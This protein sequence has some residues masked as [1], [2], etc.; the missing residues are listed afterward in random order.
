MTTDSDGLR[1]ASGKEPQMEASKWLTV[2][3]LLDLEEMQ[4]LFSALS[5]FHIYTTGNIVDR[6]KS[7][8]SLKDFLNIY[9]EYISDLKRG[10]FTE[11]PQRSLIFSS[12]FSVDPDALYAIPIGQERQLARLYKPA[13]QLQPHAFVYSPLDGKFYSMVLGQNTISWGI[14]F[15]FPQLY[16]DPGTK[17]IIQVKN[18]FKNT[19]LFHRIQKWMRQNTIPTPFQVS[20]RQ[21]NAPMRLGKQCLPWINQHPGFSRHGIL[22]SKEAYRKK[23]LP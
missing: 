7:E 13:V 22:V 6:G 18:N 12:V 10:N 2:S 19:D 11:N 3:A 8:I 20:E 23:T 5:P 21:I 14:Q 15:S 17:E 9:A 1:L 4:Q 16:Q